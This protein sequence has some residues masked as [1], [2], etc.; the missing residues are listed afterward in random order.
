MK[1]H[2]FTL[3]SQCYRCMYVALIKPILSILSSFSIAAAALGA[4]TYHKC[5]FNNSVLLA[6]CVLP[7]T[8]LLVMVSA[9]VCK[10]DPFFIHLI[11]LSSNRTVLELGSAYRWEHRDQPLTVASSPH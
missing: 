10:L 3:L 11:H 7:L 5:R 6:L 4:T 9:I 1:S 2:I 8:S